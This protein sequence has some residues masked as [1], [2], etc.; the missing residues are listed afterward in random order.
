MAERERTRRRERGVG[1]ASQDPRPLPPHRRAVQRDRRRR[2]R[3]TLH[4]HILDT[5]RPQGPRRRSHHGSGRHAR[6]QPGARVGGGIARV[7]HRLQGRIEQALIAEVGGQGRALGQQPDDPRGRREI[8]LDASVQTRPGRRAPG[9]A[10]GVAGCDRHDLGQGREPEH[11]L[12][13]RADV[14]R[15]GHDG[16]A[17]GPEILQRAADLVPVGHPAGEDLHHAAVLHRRAGELP[18]ARPAVERDPEYGALLP[19]GRV[20]ADRLGEQ[21]PLAGV[22][23]RQHRIEHLV[24]REGEQHHVE[25]AGV[26]RGP[27][28]R[29]AHPVGVEPATAVQ[30]EGPDPRL[31]QELLQDRRRVGAEPVGV[32]G[33]PDVLEASPEGLRQRRGVDPR[34]QQRDPDAGHRRTETVQGTE[35]LRLRVGDRVSDVHG[36]LHRKIGGRRSGDK[37]RQQS[38]RE[39]ERQ[40]DGQDRVT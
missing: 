26:P 6:I 20:G 29:V 28:Q 27:A 15:G 35:R 7:P 25:V 9:D 3:A 39:R 19:G 21:V 37:P 34:G 11:G 32:A 5:L 40:A 10:G 23:R 13:A 31:L 14:T 30:R 16:H 38:Q 8:G 33:P 4:R 12:Q 22:H 36:Q 17:R 2:E 18:G 1:D 24:G